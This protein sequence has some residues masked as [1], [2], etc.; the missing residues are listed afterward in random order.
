M[1]ARALPQCRPRLSSA[2]RFH[3]Q[4]CENGLPGGRS[5]RHFEHVATHL[6]LVLGL[7][8]DL[9]AGLLIE[10]LILGALAGCFIY[11]WCGARLDSYK[12]WREG[13]KQGRQQ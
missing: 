11:L 6:H 9:A 1:A 7:D 3:S 10:S 12:A 4:S 13:R 5:A 2:D 8:A